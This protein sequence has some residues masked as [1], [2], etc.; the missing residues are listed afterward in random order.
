MVSEYRSNPLVLT[1][2]FDAAAQDRFEALRQAHF[3]P[4]RNLV[5]AH[6]TLFHSLPGVREAEIA[7]T[8]AALADRTPALPFRTAGPLVLG[9]G[10]ALGVDCPGLA[11][12]HAELRHAWLDD[13]TPQDRQPLRPHVTVQ[14]KVDPVVARATAEAI[15][16][17]APIRG[18][19][20]GLLLWRYLGGPWERIA[21][22]VFAGGIE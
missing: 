3:P 17:L 10:V 20:E 1:L 14:N 19:A 18:V 5:P 7:V 6:L 16:A 9:R 2:A 12:L 11:D 21:R 13:L 8:A 4:C 15:A 22:Y